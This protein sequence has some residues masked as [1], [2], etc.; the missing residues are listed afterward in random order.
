MIQHEMEMDPEIP[1][2]VEL[3][4][5]TGTSCMFDGVGRCG[6]SLL[7]ARSFHS[8]AVPSQDK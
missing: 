4:N 3:F 7:C 6:S 5:S 1:L 8:G 2:R